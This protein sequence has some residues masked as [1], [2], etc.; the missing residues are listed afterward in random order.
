LQTLQ[1]STNDSLDRPKTSKPTQWA[2]I[3]LWARRQADRVGEV[4]F[5]APR[6]VAILGREDER[7]GNQLRWIRHRP[8][9]DGR[10]G[11][12]ES[13]YVSREQLRLKPGA[14]GLEAHNVGRIAM[15]VNG[16]AM[17]R[18]TLRVNDVVELDKEW[19]FLVSRRQREF[20]GGDGPFAAPDEAGFVGESPAMHGLRHEIGR[21]GPLKGHGL[22]LGPSGSGKELAARA[23]HDASGRSGSWVACNA[24]ALPEKLLG[25][26]LFGNI[27]DYPH[28]GMP[29][30]KGLAG[31]ASEGTL[32]L[33]EVGELPQSVQA[34]LLRLLD[35]GEVQ[36]LGADRPVS[37][38]VRVVAATNRDEQRLKH[39][40][41]ARFSH[42]IR[43]PGL[44]ERPEDVPLLARHLLHGMRAQDAGL[45]RFFRNGQPLL[46]PG[47]I[48]GLVR[49][50]WTAHIRELERLLWDCIGD[51]E[52]PYIDRSQPLT[53]PA[54]PSPPE[55]L[56]AAQIQD[57]LDQCGGVKARAWKALG[58]RNRHQLR[59]L[60]EKHGL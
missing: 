54:A 55:S 26:E 38:D 16:N 19:L 51:S 10:G 23:L 3:V 52:G 5:I 42:R 25:A 12:L 15:K 49:H 60:M 56:T 11:P 43:V 28:S 6:R 18:A 21:I 7:G 48:T 2:L 47:L 46:T 29:F 9:A 39:D 34:Q 36:R 14:H 58:L 53:P 37:V 33:D 50:H 59:R 13:P 41:L 35:S 8:G 30:R 4:A 22:L 57:A 1:P 17:E 27:A 40:V 31:Q 32:F 45:D 20:P 44:N 24:A